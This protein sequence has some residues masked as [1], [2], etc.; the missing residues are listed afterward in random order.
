MKRV[1]LIKILTCVLVSLCVCLSLL[2]SGCQARAQKMV[3]EV[4][5]QIPYSVS[6]NEVT[7]PM[8]PNPRWG[9]GISK[10]EL[11]W[12]L[13]DALERSSFDMPPTGD[14]QNYILDVAVLDYDKPWHGSA[15]TVC[16]KTKWTLKEAETKN[17]VWQDTFSSAYK[18]GWI[19]SLGSVADRGR[20]Q[21]AQ[22]GVARKNIMEGL[23]QLS[24]L[25]L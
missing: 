19:T 6:V 23:R 9:A 17:V 22:E 7:V 5:L 10:T 12:A 16:M 18:T 11:K 2:A 13:E 20:L 1:S 25:G 14:S 4:Y 21:Q 24:L 15:M 8:E 3:P